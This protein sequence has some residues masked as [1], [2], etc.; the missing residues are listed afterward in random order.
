MNFS[1]R[2]LSLHKSVRRRFP[3]RSYRAKYPSQFWQADLVEMIPF[4]RINKG[5]K[6]I[7]TIV[8]VFSRF[9]WAIGLKNKS[10]TSVTDAFKQIFKKTKPPTYLHTDEGKEFENKTVRDYLKTKDTHQFSV[11]S[12]FKAS[13]CERFN[14]Q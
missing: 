6:Y 7:L 12:E 4:S 13:I 9:A 10:A 3:V 11:K 8:D 1:S 5:F 2:A 14:R